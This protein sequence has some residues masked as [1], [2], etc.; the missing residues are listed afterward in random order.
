MRTSSRPRLFALAALAAALLLPLAGCDSGGDRD[1]FNIGDYVGTYRGGFKGRSSFFG[2]TQTVDE[3]GTA[4]FAKTGAGTVTLTFMNGAS[5]PDAEPEAIPGTYDE[6]GM[7]FTLTDEDTGQR[8]PF[9]VNAAGEVEGSVALAE[10]GITGTLTVSGSLTPRRFVFR[11]ELSSVP[12]LV[13]LDV[14]FDGKK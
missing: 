5:G 13:G 7:A 4:T 10:E 2:Q 9:T 11:Q 6:N 12:P 3:A 14:T 1:G 8:L